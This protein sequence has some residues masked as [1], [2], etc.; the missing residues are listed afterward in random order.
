MPRVQEIV[1]PTQQACVRRVVPAEPGERFV[2][3][4]LEKCPRIAASAI[5]RD[6]RALTA[7]SG[8]DVSPHLD[9]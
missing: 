7:V 5:R 9:G 6:E 4:E 2:V 1:S 8:V 3:I